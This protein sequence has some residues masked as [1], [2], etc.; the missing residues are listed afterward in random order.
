MPPVSFGGGTQAVHK[1][2]ALSALILPAVIILSGTIA[3]LASVDSIPVYGYEVVNTFP[4]EPSAFTQGLVYH[5]GYLYEGTGLYG[6]SQL[7]KLVLETGEV[8][9]RRGLSSSFFGEGVTIFRDRIYQ[10]T[11]KRRVGFVYVE[12]EE[13]EIESTFEY[14]YPG[15]GLTHDDT[16]LI[17]SDGTDNLY[18]LDPETFEEV[19]RVSVTADGLPV[20]R[21][22][23][24]ELIQGHIFANIL[25]SDRI[26]IIETGTGEVVGWLDLAGILQ[27]DESTRFS[28]PLNG[29]AFDPD[30]ARLFVTGKKWPDLFEI[31]I[32]PLE[33]PPGREMV[34]LSQNRPNPFRPETTIDFTI[35]GG[36]GRSRAVTLTVYDIMGR[37][38]RALAD[39]E[40]PPGKHEV[41]WDGRD[42]RGGR[43][44]AGVYF[45]VLSVGDTEIAR[46][47]TVLE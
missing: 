36:A 27:E 14:S 17:M 15:W 28:G 2:V 23:E 11:W 3:S 1:W 18:F 24:L 7:R 5:D 47:M 44:S 39:S 13:F 46:K 26:A 41:K 31:L 40:F 29:I 32:A 4:H 8:V 10:L 16:S 12:R 38:V 9:K 22:N 25:D 21:L 30:G 35:S 37:Q 43:V 20:T 19:R 42:D 33:Y 6:G 34:R 45:Y